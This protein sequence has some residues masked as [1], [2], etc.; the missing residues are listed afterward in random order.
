MNIMDRDKKYIMQTYRRYDLILTKGKG[1][2]VWD[3]KG[4]K[5]LDFFAGLSVC[6]VGHCHPRVVSAIRRQSARLMHASNLYY[7]EPQV[8]LAERLVRAS[9]PGRVFFSNSGAEANECAIKLA[10]KWG[11]NAGKN[12]YEIIAFKNSFHGR[13]IATLSATGQKKFHKGFEP[14]LA[15]FRYAEFNDLKSVRE[16]LN[17]KTCAVIVEPVQGEGGVFPATKEF[18]KGLRA[19][20]DRH[21]LLLIFDEIQSGMGRTGRL[22]ASQ[23]Y[24]VDPDILTLAK[25][26]GGGLPIGVT[27]TGVKAASLFGFGD[28]GSTFGGN[29]ISCAAAVEVLKVLTPSFLKSVRSNGAHFISRLIELKSKYDFIKD[30]RGMGLMAGLELDFPGKDIVKLCQDR[31]LLINCTQDKILRFLPPLIINR[32]DIDKAVGILDSAFAMIKTHASGR[33]L[34]ASGKV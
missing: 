30:V 5:Y 31:G 11:K 9:F 6:N 10:R 1:K 18:L 4:R 16:L 28:H 29:L 3:E 8:E 24:G 22:L 15:G 7:T 14:M 17:S 27:I 2:Y 12:K 26:L 20:C 25:S 21:G 19:I 32:Q 13:T 23:N 33:K 34:Q